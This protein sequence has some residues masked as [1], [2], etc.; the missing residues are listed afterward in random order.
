MLAIVATLKVNEGRNA[1]FEAAFREA[2]AGVRANE[3]KNSL[4]Q[5][6]RSRDE[7]Q[8][9]RVMELYT[10]DAALDAHRDSEHFKALGPKLKGVLAER[11]VIILHD[12][13]G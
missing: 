3:P 8:T 10:D 11:P 6:V 5:L 7:P 12:T 2:M 1:D 4:Y 13:V 9:Y